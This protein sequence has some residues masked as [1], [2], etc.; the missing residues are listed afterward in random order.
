MARN[1]PDAL[2]EVERMMDVGA[3]GS[4]VSTMALLSIARDI[5]EMLRMMQGEHDGF[6]D[7]IKTNSAKAPAQKGSGRGRQ[8]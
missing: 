1:I 8:S 3:V 4:G 5:R 6:P 7:G 2:A